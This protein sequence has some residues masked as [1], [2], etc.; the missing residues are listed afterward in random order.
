MKKDLIIGI[1]G[2]L[3]AGKGT[4]V[5]YLKEKGFKHYS[6]REYITQEI[7]RRGMPVNRDSMVIVGNDLREK[8]GPSHVAEALYE[9]AA[10]EGGSCILESL[11]TPGEIEALRKK[12]NFHLFAIDADPKLRYERILLR[13]T[14]TDR[15]SFEEF[16]ANEKREMESDD[17]NKLNLSKTK[18]MANFVF[19]NSRTF[20]DLY[21][22]VDKV[23]DKIN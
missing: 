3:G 15:I 18:E 20:N 2:T 13:K 17:P 22:Q 11:R 19:D 23:L 5:D 4:I 9:Q 10:E 1:T 12:G 16:L 21:E 8:Y 7:K 14:E 6:A